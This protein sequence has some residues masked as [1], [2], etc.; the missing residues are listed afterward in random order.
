MPIIEGIRLLR[1]KVATFSALELK[2]QSL[3]GVSKGPPKSEYI[4]II[5]I[6]RVGYQGW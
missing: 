5:K 4:R 6:T 2:G 1:E 3:N